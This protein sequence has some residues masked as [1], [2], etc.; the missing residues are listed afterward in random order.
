MWGN[1]SSWYVK[2]E[3]CKRGD[4]RM[5]AKLERT[6]DNNNVILCANI[7]NVCVDDA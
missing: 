7:S 3:I 6:S 5:L 1:G 4:S 2:C